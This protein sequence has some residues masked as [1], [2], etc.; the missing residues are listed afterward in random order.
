MGTRHGGGGDKRPK[1]P[2]DP[3]D[4]CQFADDDTLES[5]FEAN[6]GDDGIMSCETLNDIW[7]TIGNDKKR[8]AWKFCKAY[9]EDDDPGLSL[10]EFRNLCAHTPTPNDAP[11][12]SDCGVLFAQL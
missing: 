1:P 12:D 2:K 11:D 3:F 8:G 6:S 4:G 7:T 10:A 9:D 5:V